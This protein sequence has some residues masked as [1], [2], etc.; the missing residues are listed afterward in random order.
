MAM[1]P[2]GSIIDE[3][4]WGTRQKCAKCARR[5]AGRDQ[6]ASEAPQLA[7]DLGVLVNRRTLA[8]VG[9]T[10]KGIAMCSRGNASHTRQTP[11][12]QKGADG[13]QVATRRTRWTKASSSAIARGAS[14]SASL[15]LC[16]FA[17]L[18]PFRLAGPQF[19]PPALLALSAIILCEMILSSPRQA[20]SSPSVGPAN[21]SGALSEFR[22]LLP[23]LPIRG[24][25]PFVK[26]PA[27]QARTPSVPLP[28]R[29]LW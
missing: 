5:R 7:R 17:F 21:I 18:P 28:I 6:R 9:A 8:R 26:P 10:G 19:L 15:R 29:G 16:A 27:S 1:P 23:P 24:D 25:L 2:P 14:P 11:H 22:C 3:A 12:D 20:P 4:V 13:P